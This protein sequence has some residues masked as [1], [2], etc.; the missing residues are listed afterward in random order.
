MEKLSDNEQ[1]AKLQKR[2]MEVEKMMEERN[3][4]LLEQEQQITVLTKSE[5]S[6]KTNVKEKIKRIDDLERELTMSGEAYEG[7][8]AKLYE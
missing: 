7:K 8:I 6:L 4:A 5:T 1:L 3:G 2:L